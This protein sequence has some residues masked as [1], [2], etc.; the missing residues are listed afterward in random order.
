MKRGEQRPK[1][2]H[3]VLIVALCMAGICFSL[4]IL[5]VWSVI[6]SNGANSYWRVLIVSTFSSAALRALQDMMASHSQD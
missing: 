3:V 2:T 4:G 1:S 6:K 5:L